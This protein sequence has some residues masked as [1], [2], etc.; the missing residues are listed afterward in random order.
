MVKITLRRNMILARVMWAGI[1]FPS[2]ESII[3]SPAKQRGFSLLQKGKNPFCKGIP[4]TWHGPLPHCIINVF[5]IYS[6]TKKKDMLIFRLG[7][8]S[9]SSCIVIVEK[10]P[11]FLSTSPYI[12]SFTCGRPHVQTNDFFLT[13]PPMDPTKAKCN[14]KISIAC[15]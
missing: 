8:S 4:L 2:R 6:C 3:H 14:W 9:L 5:R 13:T 15:L 7:H 12:L 11:F 10:G 1:F